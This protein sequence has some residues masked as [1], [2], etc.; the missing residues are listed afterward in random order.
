M[1]GRIRN[2]M[3]IDTVRQRV[4]KSLAARLP[5]PPESLGYLNSML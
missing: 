2:R 1:A 4:Q 3:E 5:P